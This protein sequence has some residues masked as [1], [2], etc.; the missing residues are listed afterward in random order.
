[1]I[2]KQVSG[3]WDKASALRVQSIANAWD[4][5]QTAEAATSAA[6]SKASVAQEEADAQWGNSTVADLGNVLGYGVSTPEDAATSALWG[7]LKP[8]DLTLIASWDRTLVAVDL[9]LKLIYNPKPAEKDKQVSA[10]FKRSGEFKR[11]VDPSIALELSLYVPR[12]PLAFNFGGKAYMPAT[13]PQVY[14]DFHYSPERLGITPVDSGSS[15]IRWGNASTVERAYAMWWGNAIVCNGNLTTIVYPDY[16]GPI[17]VVPVPTEPELQESYMIGNLVTVTETVTGVP[18]LAQN[19]QLN[20]DASSFSW[21]LGMDVLGRGSMEAIRPDHTGIKQVLVDINGHQWVFLVERYRRSFKFAQEAYSITGSSR[22]QL[23]TA[24]YAQPISGAN[25]AP[26]TARQIMDELVLNTG[27]TINWPTFGDG[28]VPDWIVPAQAF[29]YQNQTPLQLIARISGA[30]GAITKPSQT[31]DVINIVPRYLVPVWQW[32]TGICE[33]IL[34]SALITNLGGEWTPNPAWDSCYVSGTNHGVGVL[35]TRRGKAGVLPAPDVFDDIL[36]DP[37]ANQYR[38][39]VEISKG[40]DQELVTL[41]LPLFSPSNP[42]APGL[43]TAGML[44]DVREVDVQWIGSCLSTQISCS[45]VGASVVTQ[46]LKL[47][48]HTEEI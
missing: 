28:A 43:V 29:S 47:E 17:V 22:T 35:A 39:A 5:M 48:R 41:Q 45:G 14:F 37:T 31:L 15:R 12:T 44:C 21:S 18:I 27:F 26:I 6:W 33:K 19:I 30:I 9:R 13:T 38:A 36:A 32:E 4:A 11:P 46:T 10:R 1:M 40:G 7:D 2:N 25:S 24:P 16:V 8:T 20:Y 23:L 3:R 34:P 42:N